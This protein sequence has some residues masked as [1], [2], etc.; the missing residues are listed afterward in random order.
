MHAAEGLTGHEPMETGFFTHVHCFCIQ[1]AAFSDHLADEQVDAYGGEDDR[2]SGYQP[3]TMHTG[4][5]SNASYSSP[6]LTAVHDGSEEVIT[7][8]LAAL[9]SADFLCIGSHICKDA[10]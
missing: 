3:R 9:E 7:A 5:S 8:T 1:C 2:P 10:P 4:L 6:Q